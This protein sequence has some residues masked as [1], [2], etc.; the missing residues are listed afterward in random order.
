[1]IGSG[2]MTGLPP[3]IFHFQVTGGTF[4]VGPAMVVFTM[5]GAYD[6]VALG[7]AVIG[8]LYN[9]AGPGFTGPLTPVAP[10]DCATVAVPYGKEADGPS[11][12]EDLLGPGWAQ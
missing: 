1:M 7:G 4:G 8:S 6:V 10:V 2:H 3:N 11:G 5:E 12:F 9:D